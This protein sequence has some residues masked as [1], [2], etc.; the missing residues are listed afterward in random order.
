MHCLIP[1]LP[2]ALLLL[3]PAD[4]DPA[5]KAFYITALQ[6]LAHEVLLEY[7]DGLASQDI[8][9]YIKGEIPNINSRIRN[10]HVV[11][12]GLAAAWNASQ[13]KAAWSNKQEPDTWADTR[14][15]ITKAEGNRSAAVLLTSNKAR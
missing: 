8:I 7:D 5:G 2:H 1:A 13:L 11:A 14:K 3:S 4:K 9:S 6:T 12:D 10:G 15:R